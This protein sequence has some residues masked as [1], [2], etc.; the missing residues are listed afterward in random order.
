[1]SLRNA[2]A[3]N[4]SDS[5]VAKNTSRFNYGELDMAFTLGSKLMFTEYKRSVIAPST[6]A[7]QAN[8]MV[9]NNVFAPQGKNNLTS[10]FSQM[11]FEYDIYTLNFNLNYVD[12]NIKGI[13]QRVLAVMHVSLK[14]QW[15]L[16]AMIEIGSR[17]C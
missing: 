14:V 8:N 5:L 10:F 17:E 13:N 2:N 4:I 3:E 9:E 11:K 6:D 7:W 1:M 15:I 12:Y 16:I